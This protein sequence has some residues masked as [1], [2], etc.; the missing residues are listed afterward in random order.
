MGRGARSASGF[1][2]FALVLGAS[3]AA[4]TAGEGPAASAPTSKAEPVAEA[5]KAD[6][7]AAKT[8]AQ[9][10][11]RAGR[12]ADAVPHAERALTLSTSLY[13]A[14][15][16]VTGVA[17]HNLGFLLRR[18]D[19]NAD[20]QPHL[21]RALG[22][23]ER[24]NPAIHDDTR[25]VVGELGHIYLKLGR[26]SDLAAL[27]AR[28]IARAA[29]EG[30]GAHIAVAHLRTNRAFVLRGLGRK[31]ESAAEFDVA[32]S[33]YEAQGAFG[34]E[35]YRLALE[36]AIEHRE[37]S[38][39]LDE[40]RDRALAAV[41][42]LD[43]GVPAEAYLIAR[44]RN[45]LSRIA[46]DGGNYNDARAQA[47]AALAAAAA[48][49]RETGPDPAI[50]A[51]N[52]LAR[53]ERALANY[54]AAE[55][56]YKRAIELLDAR[57]DTVSS[58]IVND[59]LAVLY[60]YLGRLAEAE[61]HHKRAV[62]LL[63]GALGREHASVGRAAANFGTMLGQAGRYTEAEPLLR[64]GIAIAEAQ[65][66]A[67]ALWMAVM[68]DNL[69]GLLRSTGR[70]KEARN[71]FQTALSL[72]EKT[73]PPEHPSIATARNNWGRY[74]IDVAALDEAEPHL[75]QALAVSEKIYGA[76]HVNIAVSASNLA[77]LLGASGRREEAR[78]LFQ[79]AISV[80]EQWLGREH[81]N[82][83][84]TLAASAKLELAEGRPAEARVLFERAMGIAL[85][86]RSRAAI[87]S[88]VKPG[89]GEAGRQTFLGL[90]D[91][92]WAEGRDAGSRNAARAL[93]V[94]QWDGMTSAAAALAALGARAGA[95]DP[96]LKALTR[97]RQDLAADWTVSDRRLTEM[98]A[99]GAGRDT[100]LENELRQR[101]A[102]IEARLR[103]IDGE[104][105]TAY[106]RYRD[107]AQPTPID[108][109]GLRR[110]LS[111]NEAA[112]QFVVAPDATHVFVVT[113][114]ELQWHRV[115]IT[116][117]EL[118]RLVRAL[119]CGLDRAEWAVEQRCTK[120][121]GLAEGAKPGWSEPLPFDID[122]AR[123]LYEFLLGPS[124]SLLA[125]KD[126]LVVP[127]GPLT[128]LPFHVLVEDE[129]P[130]VPVAAAQANPYAHVG[131]LGRRH[132]VTVLPSLSSLS[133]LRQMARASTAPK[134][135]LGFGNPLLIGVD[136]ADRSAVDVSPCVI[137]QQE[138]ARSHSGAPPKSF[139]RGATAGAGVEALRRQP[140]LPETADE[141]CRVASFLHASTGDVIVGAKA[142]EGALKQ[143]SGT[144]ELASARV[145]HFAT[146]GLLAD[147]TAQFLGR[148]EPSL[149]LTPP[150]NEGSELDDGLLTASEVAALRLDADWVVLSACN[151]ASG[152]DVG[153]EALSGLARAF[154][155]AG[156]RS[157]LVSHWAVNSDAT[158]KLVTAAFQAM[159]R[160]PQLTQAQ[161]MRLAMSHLIDSGGY[162]S[163]P[164]A[165]APF[166]VVG[167]SSPVGISATGSA[168]KP[169]VPAQTRFRPKAKPKG[170]KAKDNWAEQFFDK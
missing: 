148:S 106:P 105:A 69:A 120:L 66:P 29:A 42:K 166:V 103:A 40:A 150:A 41:A 6:L 160:D 134:P 117:R 170:S 152:E 127:S 56:N 129:E 85:A 156:A 1:L 147:E 33:L 92:I 112:V 82:L 80:L 161:A 35:A 24:L 28:L 99:E 155:Y 163:H 2:A 158:V 149:V 75:R 67:D 139:V 51:L 4:A 167:G 22:L 15:A 8:A 94:G 109:D 151:T 108:V 27:Y 87:Q 169:A 140:P 49:R 46:H 165:W 107:L 19:R 137:Q 113:G 11:M 54:A 95:S 26:G 111:P 119:R 32:A 118:G 72:F 93:V 135:Y 110:L 131:F 122:R 57:R 61:R 130:R 143:M 45:R 86:T 30:D 153:A 100:V 48:G 64:R 34:S 133:A 25:N 23:Y 114:R 123:K 91:A 142:T 52:N 53:A 14:D 77:E 68:H 90:M 31:D 7:E 154:F 38:G 157:L 10:L 102:R 97:E 16:L 12:F 162:L 37:A 138:V 121:L 43:Q 73:L 13:G 21:E 115:P 116:D 89:Q 55:A 65:Q 60:L 146:H 79:R 84:P 96:K 83:L 47:E 168:M 62:A 125:G 36:A 39:R 126:L 44:L 145:L 78:G 98:L 74:L 132:A 18:A 104:L 59:N 50:D 141:L 101:I 70:M 164:S 128:S 3:M 9:T 136:G 17:A 20:A 124:R 76:D 71:H 58:G 63:E 5:A 159:S 81:P 88:D 144:G